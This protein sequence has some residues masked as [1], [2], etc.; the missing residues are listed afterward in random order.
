VGK[1]EGRGKGDWLRE[2][3]WRWGRL[4]MSNGVVVRERGRSGGG[5]GWGWEKREK[6]SEWE[7]RECYG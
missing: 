1:V 7:K 2:E 6:G 4:R 3:G 5:E